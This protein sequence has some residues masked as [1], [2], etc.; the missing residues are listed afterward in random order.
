MIRTTLSGGSRY[1]WALPGWNPYD[2][3]GHGYAGL[4]LD[5]TDVVGLATQVAACL[6]SG[7]NAAKS[8]CLL[9]LL[10]SRTTA[11][12]DLDALVATI[13]TVTP[14]QL[15]ELLGITDSD[16]L[17]ASAVTPFW[18]E[19]QSWAGQRVADRQWQEQ[20]EASEARWA[21]ADCR[22]MSAADGGGTL[23][24]FPDG[25]RV[26]T[27]VGTVPGGPSII[28]IGPEGAACGPGMGGQ[29]GTPPARKSL[30]LRAAGPSRF[31]SFDPTRYRTPVRK[32]GAPPPAA[33]PWSTGKKAAVAVGVVGVLGVLAWVLKAKVFL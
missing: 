4:G 11:Q 15:L 22:Q 25:E 1:Q 10:I 18:A 2:V 13:P 9:N 31:V 32:D 33:A 28:S 8:E 12:V 29:E 3:T 14:A 7:S 27:C 30:L 24:S 5:A 20:V 16:G 23:C 21:S 17:L 6:L 19:L 26:R